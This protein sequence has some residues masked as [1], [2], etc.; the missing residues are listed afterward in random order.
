MLPCSSKRQILT[1]VLT[2]T[3]YASAYLL[4]KP[5]GVIK[6]DL[7]SIYNLSP[8]V[9]GWL[10][11]CY[12]LPY[13]FFSIIFGNL[14][15]KYGNRKILTC[16]LICMGLSMISFGYWSSP[17]AFAILLF[18]NGSAQANLWSNCVKSLSDWYEP[19]KRAT[20]FGIWG[21]C[22]FAGGIMGTTLAVQLQKAF[23][24]EIKMVFV[25]PSIWVII[26]AVIVYIFLRSPTEVRV[27]VIQTDKESLLP[28]TEQPLPT[29]RNLNILETWRLRMVPELCWT[30]FGMKL[31]RYCLYMW[32]PMYLNQN[33][34]Y[35]KAE[36]GMFSTLYEIGGVVGS[37]FIG[38]FIDKVMRGNTYMGVFVLLT[39]STAALC[40]FQLTSQC[41]MVMNAIF[42]FLAGAGSSGPDAVIS[43]SLAVEIGTRENAQSA[44]SGLINGFGSLGAILEGPFIAM[45]LTYFGWSGTFY[46][47]VLLTFL[48]AVSIAR[49]AFQK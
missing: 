25:V 47:M 27:P 17:M 4:R 26:L 29:Q 31:V 6:T 49:P 34:N 42:L 19:E 1:Y 8:Q 40:L 46:V 9:L 11:S 37:A 35:S 10:D 3:I 18:I 41:G 14:G 13:A 16:C 43:G 23:P 5:L 21:T 15:D 48:S 12:L 45:V 24:G 36:A 28:V 22:I 32:L 7:I 39:L 20:I 33:L 2:W 44:V 38:L 30:M